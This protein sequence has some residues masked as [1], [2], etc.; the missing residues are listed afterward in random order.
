MR[1]LRLALCVLGVVILA[2]TRSSPTEYPYSVVPG[3]LPA[4]HVL[5]Q[6]EC[7]YLGMRFAG[8]LMWTDH[9][10]WLKAGEKMAG[11]RRARCG[12]PTASHLPPGAQ[13]LPPGLRFVVPIMEKPLPNIVAPPQTTLMELTWTPPGE[14][15]PPG[16]QSEIHLLPLPYFFLPF[17]AVA[18]PPPCKHKPCKR[19]LPSH[20]TPEPSSVWLL[21]SGVSVLALLIGLNHRRPEKGFRSFRLLRPP[22]GQ[23]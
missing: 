6:A 22:V 2:P 18:P 16:Q 14:L 20:A 23:R 15:T 13:T 12:N 1:G 7:L 21:V 4:D 10:I 9:C 3:G 19:P 8:Q 5:P 17:W 11:K